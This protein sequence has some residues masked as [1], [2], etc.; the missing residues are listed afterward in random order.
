[1]LNFRSAVVLR[2]FI[3]VDRRHMGRVSVEIRPPDAKFVPVRIDPLPKLFTGSPSL[4]PCAA[5]DAH[6]IGSKPVAVAAAEAPTVV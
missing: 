3:A 6:D 1:M 2:I 4:V 5:L